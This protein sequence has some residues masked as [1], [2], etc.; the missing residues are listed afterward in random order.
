MPCRSVNEGTAEAIGI[1]LYIC[2]ESAEITSVLSFLATSIDI[3][4]FPDAVGPTMA[5][6]FLFN[7]I[8]NYL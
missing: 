4:V 3:E 6:H 7:D 8:K 2:R 1:C 5:M